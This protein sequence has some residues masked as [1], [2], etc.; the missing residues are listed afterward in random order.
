MTKS[1]LKPD[2]P[3]LL[4]VPFDANSSYLRGA[5]KAPP[6]IRK[7]FHCDSSNMWTETG[8][9]L[10]IPGSFADAGDIKFP[11]GKKPFE[12]IDRSLSGLLEKGQRPVCLGGD[13]SV[14]YP[15]VR[16]F[17]KKYSDLTIIHFDAH[18]DLYDVLDGN[19]FSHACPF[20]RIMEEGR[21][22]RLI[23]VGIRTL[24]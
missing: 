19:R 14:T 9:D 16:A 5:A 8:V 23:Q 7:A 13:H 2:I 11:Q 10:A 15:I 6:L 17:S 3:V 20:A 1:R 12:L 21:A 4:G 24:N 22:K 18:S